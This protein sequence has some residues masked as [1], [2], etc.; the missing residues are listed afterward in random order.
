VY[1]RYPEG[2]ELDLP[3]LGLAG[4]T[5]QWLVDRR[6][7]GQAGIIAAVISADGPH[8]ALDND[9]LIT[10]VKEEIARCV[11]ALPAA[12]DARVIRE[13]RATFA[14]TVGI[15]RRRPAARTALHGFMLAGDW[16][17]TGL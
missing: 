4:M 13:K 6:T 12:S 5:T 9:A 8:M 11:P 17:A 16:T 2:T 1:L 10:L 3:L 15:E 7:C 14:A